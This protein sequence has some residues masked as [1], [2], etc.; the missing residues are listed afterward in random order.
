MPHRSKCCDIVGTEISFLK[1]RLL[2]VED[3]LALLPG[4]SIGKLIKVWE[5]KFGKLRSSTTPADSSIQ[6]EDNSPC[7]VGS[8][9]T[10][11]RMAVGTCLYIIRD[12]PDI[13]FTVKELSSYMSSVSDAASQGTCF[14]FEGNQ[15]LCS[16]APTTS[17][18]T[19]LAQTNQ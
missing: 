12:R 1:R 14:L 10:F 2:R 6:M 13:A 19:R 11:F 18:R 16:C 4:S 5:E 8:D 9:V 7:L 15:S 17:W 3:G